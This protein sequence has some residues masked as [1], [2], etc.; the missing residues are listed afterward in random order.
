MISGNLREQSIK[1]LVEA[2]IDKDDARFDIDLLLEHFDSEGDEAFLDAVKE[3]AE[4]KPSAYIIGH[5]CFYMD[6]FNVVP[7]VLIPRSDTEILVESALKFMGAVTFPMGDV[8]LIPEHERTSSYEVADLCTGTG[9]IGISVAKCMHDAGIDIN[10]TLADIS[11]VALECAK[12]NLNR[13]Y[14]HNVVAKK[15]NVLADDYINI[16]GN[17]LDAIIS[18]PPYITDSEM[19]ELPFDVKNFEPDLALRAKLDGLEFYYELAKRSKVAL[20]E[21]G[22]LIVE[23]GYLQGRAVREIFETNGFT[24]VVTIKDYGGNDRVTFGRVK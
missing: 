16:S 2:G 4:G 19:E 15:F 10:M 23:H 22:A 18:N 12:S 21:G 1:R 8:A 6:D 5:K 17:K 14:G 3:R 9:C 24:D 13:V 20:K 11:D 7:G